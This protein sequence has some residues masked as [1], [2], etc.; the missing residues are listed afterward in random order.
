MPTL[1]PLSSTRSNGNA[2]A[3]IYEHLEHSGDKE[4]HMTDCSQLQAMLN[5]AIQTRNDLNSPTYCED[6]FTTITEQQ[7]CRKRLPQ[8][9]RDADQNITNIMNEMKLCG[10]WSLIVQGVVET[11]THYEGSL[12]ITGLLTGTIDLPDSLGNTAFSGTYN[13]GQ[14]TIQLLRP[15]SDS[16]GSVQD[17]KGSVD[18][19]TQPASMQGQMR[20][21]YE[22]GTSGP[23]PVYD[24]SA[25][26]LS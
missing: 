15:F 12:N 13:V 11:N 20:I 7:L 21:D 1:M 18:F 3:R 26:K 23:D 25:R 6:N 9:K 17:Y 14:G 16:T 19:S 5:A 22:P 10:T 4:K 8:Q 24:W 2:S